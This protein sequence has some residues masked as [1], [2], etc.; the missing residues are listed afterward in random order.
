[1]VLWSASKSQV[2]RRVQSKPLQTDHRAFDQHEGTCS[3]LALNVK[4]LDRLQFSHGVENAIA[5]AELDL[6]LHIIAPRQR[7]A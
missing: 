7:F 3:T 5:K 6:E 2:A 1:M 4:T